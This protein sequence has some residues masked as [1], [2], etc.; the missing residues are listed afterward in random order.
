MRRANRL[1]TLRKS[2]WAGFAEEQR[3]PAHLLLELAFDER[4][5]HP[6]IAATVDDLSAKPPNRVQESI[7]EKRS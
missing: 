7:V 4:W 1:C 6:V 2:P 3:G 5:Q